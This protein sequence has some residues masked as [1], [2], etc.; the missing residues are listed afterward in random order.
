[1]FL[2]CG[3]ARKVT[4]RVSEAIEVLRISALSTY[5]DR[6]ISTGA[7]LFGFQPDACHALPSLPAGPTLFE[8]IDVDSKAF[9]ESAM[10]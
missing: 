9:I 1:M 8:R 10:D 3:G 7:L 6:R 5:E 2:R 4:D